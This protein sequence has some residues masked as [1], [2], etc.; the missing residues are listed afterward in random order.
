MESI[1]E[2]FT[3]ESLKHTLWYGNV[4]AALEHLE[5]LSCDREI[6]QWRSAAVA[7]LSRGVQELEMDARDNQLFI[8]DLGERNRQGNRISTAQARPMSADEF[9]DRFILEAITC[10]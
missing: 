5:R 10:S 2:I 6:N 7:N 4:D 9:T 3:L 1:S 8:L